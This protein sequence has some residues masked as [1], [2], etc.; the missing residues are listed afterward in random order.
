MYPQFP[1]GSSFLNNTLYHNSVTLEPYLYKLVHNHHG[2]QIWKPLQKLG[3]TA[4]LAPVYIV[5]RGSHT[6]ADWLLDAGIFLDYTTGL[7][8]AKREFDTRLHYKIYDIL[9][10]VYS[11]DD[12]K[13]LPKVF[14]GHSLAGA[15]ACRLFHY[16]EK[17][18]EG[19]DAHANS[20]CIMFNPYILVDDDYNDII[21]DCKTS[22][23]YRDKF[24][25]HMVDADVASALFSSHGFGQIHIWPKKYS[26]Y[27]DGYYSDLT[28]W[29]TFLQSGASYL[30]TGN[31]SITNFAANPMPA[32]AMESLPTSLQNEIKTI[33][34]KL[35]TFNIIDNEGNETQDQMFMVTQTPLQGGIRQPIEQFDF[36]HTGH[37]AHYFNVLISRNYTSD[38]I[39][40]SVE[41]MYDWSPTPDYPWANTRRKWF[42]PLYR[43]TNQDLGDKHYCLLHRRSTTSD[44]LYYI[45]EAIQP[46][47]TTNTYP[48]FHFVKMN[49]SG[50]L[51]LPY[52]LLQD[53]RTQFKTNIASQTLQ[54]DHKDRMTWILDQRFG[55][56]AENRPRR[57]TAL[58][59]TH[60]NSFIDIFPLDETSQFKMEYISPNDSRTYQYVTA[61]SDFPYGIDLVSYVEATW[62]GWGGIESLP[63]TATPSEMIYDLSYQ[64]GDIWKI[65]GTDTPTAGVFG[66]RFQPS[67]T[68]PLDQDCAGLSPLTDYGY[69]RFHDEGS[70]NTNNGTINAK[71]ELMCVAADSYICE[72]SSVPSGSNSSNGYY[73]YQELGTSSNASTFKFTKITSS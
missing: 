72:S 35:K 61:D 51:S 10:H 7:T 55:A 13:N 32:E 12:M 38:E 26:L 53:T 43:I 50:I 73:M 57:N 46:L 65:T 31:H 36:P 63:D 34:S 2:L 24:I 47:P 30:H 39:N 69:V 8:T 64:G 41:R 1:T 49:N 45:G 17:T 40:A 56:P 22:S 14:I 68:N 70:G 9:H 71:I 21:D 33:G 48:T 4:D 29:K 28:E 3:N 37:P 67:Y 11:D 42:S 25:T 60:A 23:T 18:H 15:E 19:A 27:N 54:A 58:S 66:K 44:Y 5:A 59:Y 20:K 16:F 6:I 52:D 62:N